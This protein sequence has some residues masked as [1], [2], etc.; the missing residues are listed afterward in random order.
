MKEIIQLI[1][2][3]PVY[4]LLIGKAV[5]GA[6]VDAF[7]APTAQSGQGYKIAFSFVNAIAFNFARAK[8]AT[9]E[10]SPNFIPAAEKYM[11]DKQAGTR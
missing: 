3:H 9:I 10:S 8:G 2:E 7:P 6:I 5:W 11:A 4:A 1:H